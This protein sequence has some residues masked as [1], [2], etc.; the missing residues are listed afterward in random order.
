MINFRYHLV[1]LVAVFL[2]LAIGIVAGSTVIKESIL[3]QTQQNLDRAEG[4]LKDLE[5][6]NAA[7]RSELDELKRRDDALDR[8]GVT[9]FLQNRLTGLPVV[10]MKVDGVD[11]AAATAMRDALIAAGASYAGTVTFTDRL[12]LATPADVAALQEV[13]SESTLDP[14][15]LRADLAAR[16]GTLMTSVADSRPASVLEPLTPSA[17]DGDDPEAP[18]TTTT[19][20]AAVLASDDVRTFLKDLDDAGFAKL[21]DQPDGAVP[22]DLGGLRLVVMSGAGAK[23]DNG[24][25]LYPFLQRM[26]GG[27][28]PSTLALEA[29]QPGSEVERG[30]FVGAIRRDGSL[31][32]HVSTVDD[33]EWFVGRAAAVMAVS[34]LTYGAVGHY[35]VG[36]GASE[37]LPGSPATSGR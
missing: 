14:T 36:E 11:D 23:V 32:E 37:L 13:L 27:A 19:P 8:A 29:T 15:A 22:L 28:E 31:S 20:S 6:S 35:G 24:M 9:D 26:V 5:N 18:T 34:A 2:A 1:S 16:L 33:G 10:L 4:N 3:D 21:S 12:A 17:T 25:F 30:S 7:L